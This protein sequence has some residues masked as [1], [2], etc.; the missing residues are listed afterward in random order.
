M[1]MKSFPI[2]SHRLLSRIV[3]GFSNYRIPL[4]VA[5]FNNHKKNTLHNASVSLKSRP[6]ELQT[7]EKKKNVLYCDPPQLISNSK[8]F[9]FLDSNY[10]VR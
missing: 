9:T 7:S 2:I 4:K 6:E 3:Q 8:L 1:H 10:R 5:L